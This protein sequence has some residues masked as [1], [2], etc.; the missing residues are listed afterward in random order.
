MPK[1]RR[2]PHVSFTGTIFPGW[3][4]YYHKMLNVNIAVLL[5]CIFL[6]FLLL[7]FF[8][9]SIYMV[10]RTTTLE[11]GASFFDYFYFSVI[12][13][14]SV[15]YGDILPK[16]SGKIIAMFQVFS[17]LIFAGTTTGIIFSRFTKT[18][19]PFIWSSPIVHYRH[20]NERFIQV[21]VTNIIANDVIDV[22]PQL[23]LQKFVKTKGGNIH[24]HLVPLKLTHSTLPIM[25]FSW[26]LSHRIDSTSPMKKW[27]EGNAQKDERLVAFIHGYDSTIGRHVYSYTRWQPEDLIDGEFENV[28]VSYGEKSDMTSIVEMDLNKIDRVIKS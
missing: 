4:F 2:Y 11:N 12:T 8:F 6:F 7:N 28:I 14:A 3:K 5:F 15:G 25:A 13:F 18:P 22:N 21:R 9:A 17:G 23:F 24:R 26:I 19:S 16:G 10:T 20:K 27:V 1:I